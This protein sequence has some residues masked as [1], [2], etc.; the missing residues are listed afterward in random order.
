MVA[1]GNTKRIGHRLTERNRGFQSMIQK[2][3]MIVGKRPESDLHKAKR[4]DIYGDMH[5]TVDVVSNKLTP[6]HPPKN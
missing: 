5:V 3:Q 6:S 4:S 2:G 1:V